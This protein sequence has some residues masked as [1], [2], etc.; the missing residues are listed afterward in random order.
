MKR[1]GDGA[2]AVLAVEEKLAAV[3]KQEGLFR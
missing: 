3:L 1:L 2:K